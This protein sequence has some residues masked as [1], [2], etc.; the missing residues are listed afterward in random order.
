MHRLWSAELVMLANGLMNLPCARQP[1]WELNKIAC[2][3]SNRLTV[4][5]CHRDIT[6]KQ[7]AGFSL[8][9]MPGERADFTGPDRPFANTQGQ[10]HTLRAVGGH[11]DHRGVG[12]GIR[13][14]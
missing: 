8:V 3:E 9:V 7:Q 14:P 12:R 11:T 10:D 6:L 13:N 1:C 5:R 4:V 2:T